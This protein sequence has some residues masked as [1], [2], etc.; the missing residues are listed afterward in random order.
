MLPR[1]SCQQRADFRSPRRQAPRPGIYHLSA[2]PHFAL[3][4]AVHGRCR[5]YGLR[6]HRRYFIIMLMLV[7]DDAAA[8]VAALLEDDAR[9]STRPLLLQYAPPCGHTPRV[10]V[11]LF[12]LWARRIGR[13]WRFIELSASPTY[14]S[15]GRRRR[16]SFR[17]L[18]F[19][20]AGHASPRAAEFHRRLQHIERRARFNTSRQIAARHYAHSLRLKIR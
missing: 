13:S 7:A 6:F 19:R 11:M 8:R 15:N 12:Q 2:I 20:P 5:R 4:V 9:D 10:R 16:F 17:C 1:L 14:Y 3:F 18:P